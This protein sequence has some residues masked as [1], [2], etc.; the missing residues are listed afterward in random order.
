VAVALAGFIPAAI[1]AGAEARP[2]VSATTG[3]Q[4]AQLPSPAVDAAAGWQ[5][6]QLPVPAGGFSD[7]A[8]YAGPIAC[9]AVGGCVVLGEYSTPT[10]ADE[11]LIATEK[12]GTW[13][14][15]RAPLPA[16]GTQ[17]TNL[18]PYTLRCT[19]VGDCLGTSLY[20]SPTSVAA[21]VVEEVGGVWSAV[22]MPVPSNLR[23]GA[24]PT[25][26]A[27]ACPLRG[28]CVVVGTY[29]T[30]SGLTEGFVV[31]QEGGQF[32][33]AQAPTPGANR[34]S[35]LAGVACLTTT[36]CVAVGSYVTTSNVEQGLFVNDDAGKLTAAT[37]PLPGNAASNPRAALQAVSCGSST[38]CVA[39]GTYENPSGDHLGFIDTDSSSKWTAA[40]MPLPSGASATS[41]SPAVYGLVCKGG[42][43]CLGVGGYTSSAGKGE[44]L[45]LVQRAGRWS[46]SM[47]PGTD[48]TNVVVRAVSCVSETSCAAAGHYQSKAGQV[49]YLMT[50]SGTTLS[51]TTSPLPS[52]ANA[53][54]G[55]D[56]GFVACPWIA[57]CAVSGTYGHSGSP[58]IQ[59]PFVVSD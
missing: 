3:S 21:D 59:L 19:G 44:G 16:G 2:A 6:A 57:T 58:P 42:D 24:F 22:A 40:K 48:N 34:G 18:G 7:G 13:T 50:L 10:G 4:A 33:A 54:P 30:T 35:I 12:S 39:V 32:V 38:L 23:T 29:E 51:G 49:G 46:A 20:Q 36:A 25:V 14:A 27:L 31:T 55:V 45:A 37:P 28:A 15:V 41:P 11:D 5:A 1:R 43:Y 17:A 47:M 53:S 8:G 56:L 26:S 52:N 9:P